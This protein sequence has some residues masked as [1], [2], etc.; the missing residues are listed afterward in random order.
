MMTERILQTTAHQTAITMLVNAE[1]Q[2]VQCWPETAVR[3]GSIHHVKFEKVSAAY[4]LAQARLENGELISVK[5]S[6][7][8]KVVSGQWGLV[9]ITAQPFEDKPAQAVASVELAGRYL[10][11]R[12]CHTGGISIRGSKKQHQQHPD[13]LEA[14][15]PA[16]AQYAEKLAGFGAHIEIVLRRSAYRLDDAA[17][18]LDEAEFLVQH[19]NSEITG[20]DDF[21]KKGQIF[22][23][24]D[25]VLLAQ[26]EAPGARA[27]AASPEM[28]D[29][30]FDQIDRLL[31]THIILNNGA[32]L[33]V[34]PTRAGV[35]IDCDGAASSLGGLALSQSLLPH[36]FHLLRLR[37]RGGRILIDFP[38]LNAS[39]RQ[40]LSAEI[41][42]IAQADSKIT[43]LH[44]FTASG[45]FE[46]VRRHSITPLEQWWVKS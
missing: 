37:A 9:T 21:D 40:K 33:W 31:E 18:L 22:S 32:E 26:L 3:L 7:G 41:E 42:K 43:S 2:V 13:R 15:Y 10:V 34:Q 46:L 8:Q 14:I 17:A 19:V 45:L 23:G 27:A 39:D 44:G 1:N 28:C 25:G 36:L 29:S 11:F 5:L 4:R 6:Y 24:F 35:M 30:Y 38:I 12:Q 20:L 16:L